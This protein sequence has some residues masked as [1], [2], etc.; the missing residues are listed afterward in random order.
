[1]ALFS[2]IDWAILLVAAAFLLLGKESQ[3]ILRT[4]GRY[5]GRAMRLK[6]ELLA[7]VAHAADLPTPAAGAPVS[8]RSALLGEST[9]PIPH[10]GHVP[11]AVTHA[12]LLTAPPS[13]STW[14]GAVGPQSWSL[15]LPASAL[16]G[17]YGP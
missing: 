11:V 13:G 5:Y 1:M 3:A 9:D 6:Q 16:D 2:D 12:P 4:I 17:R 10:T 15:A 8:L 7:E 14:T